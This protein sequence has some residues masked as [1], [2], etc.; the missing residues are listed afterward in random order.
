[1]VIISYAYNLYT[2]PLNYWCITAGTLVSLSFIV[3]NWLIVSSQGG[4]Q[5][6]AE[7]NA[8]KYG[9]IYGLVSNAEWI[10]IYGTGGLGDQ[11]RSLYLPIQ[12]KAFSLEQYCGLPPMHF[13]CRCSFMMYNTE[14][15]ISNLFIVPYRY[16]I[17][18]QPFISVTDLEILKEILITQFE[19]FTDRPVH[20]I[21][22][23]TVMCKLGITLFILSLPAKPG[24]WV[25]IA[26]S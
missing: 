1:M 10:G 26:Q 12:V 4:L 11:V 13:S 21:L 15:A 23:F 6:F 19:T 24:T 8:K 18:I 25:C 2:D 22:Y 20:I 9:N 5:K 16:Y 7:L 3:I 17:G 14:I